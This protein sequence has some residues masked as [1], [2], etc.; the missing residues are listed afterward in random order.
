MVGQFPEFV[1][2]TAGLAL[3]YMQA[4][5][6]EKCRHYFELIGSNDFVDLPREGTWLLAIGM[7]GMCCA[8]LKDERRAHILYDLLLPF[9]EKW[10]ATVVSTLGPVERVLGKLAHMLGN[11]DVAIEHLERAIEL[12]AAVPTPLFL[13]EA[14]YDLAIVLEG[15][16]PQRAADLVTTALATSDDL[17]LETLRRW[18]LPLAERLGVAVSS[19]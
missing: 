1:G 19:S 16:D 2:L 6:E 12:T 8:Y 5:D 11:R 10:V 3:G 17:D 13:A 18:A 15:T 4:D 7:S 14:C 9:R